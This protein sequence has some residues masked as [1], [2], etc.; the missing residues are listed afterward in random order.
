MQY[1]KPLAIWILIG[2]GIIVLAEFNHTAAPTFWANP[3]NHEKTFDGWFFGYVSGVD[4]YNSCF[5][6]TLAL[7]IGIGIVVTVPWGGFYVNNQVI[8]INKEVLVG[9]LISLEAFFLPFVAQLNLTGTIP[10]KIQTISMLCTAI[11]VGITYFLKY[12]GYSKEQK[13]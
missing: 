8:S 10:D 12:L 4:V 5:Y 13:A 6:S 3:Y 9:I 1:V 11:V 7:L 2:F